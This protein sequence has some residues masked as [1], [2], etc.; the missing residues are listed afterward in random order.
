MPVAVSLGYPREWIPRGHALSRAPPDPAGA[1]VEVIEKI[2][3]LPPA[4]G[5]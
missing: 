3:D 2:L 5:T 1:G 4:G